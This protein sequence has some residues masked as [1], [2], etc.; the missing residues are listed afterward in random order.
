MFFFVQRVI[1]D[2][3]LQRPQN[4]HHPEGVFVEVLADTVFQQGQVHH[5]VGAGHPDAI[6][7]IAD[8]RRGV[9]PPVQTR[10]GGHARIIPAVDMTLFNQLDQFAFAQHGVGEIQA[11]KFDL[12][13]MIDPQCIQHPVIELTVVFKFQGAQRMGNPLDGI[14]QAMGKIIHGIDAPRVARAVM[15]NVPDAVQ[16]RI[17]HDHIG[18]GHVDFGPQHMFPVFKFAGAHALK[19]VQVFSHRTVPKGAVFP[20]TGQSPPVF[21]DLIGA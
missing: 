3:N 21:T 16:G 1:V 15:G 7:E 4:P 19:Q 20:R 10:N 18:G 13:G 2:D 12:P 11:G 17:A 8:G 5:A 6:A 14:G 9:A